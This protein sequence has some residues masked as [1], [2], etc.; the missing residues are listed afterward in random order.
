MKMAPPL[1]RPGAIAPADDMY[2]P[3]SRLGA[4]LNAALWQDRGQR[5]PRHAIVEGSYPVAYVRV[6][7]A[8]AKAA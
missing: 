6:G 2:A 8:A 1:Y 4:V 7:E 5:L 3:V